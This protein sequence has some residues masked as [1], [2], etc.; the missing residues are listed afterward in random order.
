MLTGS[1]PG[2]SIVDWARLGVET[3]ANNPYPDFIKRDYYFAFGDDGLKTYTIFD[4]EK[5]KE[6]EGLKDI[7]NRLFKFGISIQGMK[8]SLEPVLTLEE[9]FASLGQIA[10]LEQASA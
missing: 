7:Q 4:I 3:L 1:C 10:T 5:G 9:L 8:A 2:T 6:E